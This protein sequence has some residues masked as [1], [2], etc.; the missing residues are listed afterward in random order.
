MPTPCAANDSLTL[1]EANC[2]LAKR[3][4]I[5]QFFNANWGPSAAADH[6][7][8]MCHWWNDTARSSATYTRNGGNLGAYL[9]EQGCR[10][11]T[12]VSPSPTV[13][14]AVTGFLAQAEAWVSAH[15]LYAVGI[16]AAAVYLFTGKRRR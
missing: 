11:S 3:P 2:I 15:P 10:G 9:R 4:D 8:I 14:P 13:P 7:A 1:A 5:Q 12:G 6:V 16:A